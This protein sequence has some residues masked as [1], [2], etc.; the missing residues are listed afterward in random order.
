M[1]A[2][3][4]VSSWATAMPFVQAASPAPLLVGV[5]PARAQG[6]ATWRGP[7]TGYWAAKDVRVGS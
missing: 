4:T 2:A 6:E 5:S 3:A 7:T 1:A